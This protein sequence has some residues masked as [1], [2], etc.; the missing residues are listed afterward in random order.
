MT[1]CAL[2]APVRLGSARIRGRSPGLSLPGMCSAGHVC[3]LRPG[4]T[5]LCCLSFLF[6]LAPPRPAGLGSPTALSLPFSAQGG[7]GGGPEFPESFQLFL[8]LSDP[9]LTLIAFLPSRRA[10]VPEHRA[11]ASSP[12]SHTTLKSPA[13]WQARR[14]S[15]DVPALLSVL[16]RCPPPRPQHRGAGLEGLSAPT[17]HK[18]LDAGVS[19]TAPD[20]RASD[21]AAT[22]RRNQ[23]LPA[24]CSATASTHGSLLQPH[25]LP[26]AIGRPERP[27]LSLHCRP[28]RWSNPHGP[29]LTHRPAFHHHHPPPSPA[30]LA[31]LAPL[32]ANQQWR[33]S[34][35]QEARP[36]QPRPP[37]TLYLCPFRAPG[38][39][40]P[41]PHTLPL[42]S[43]S[44]RTQFL[45]RTPIP[46]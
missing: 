4:L 39:P 15:G 9:H 12:G 19:A 28:S 22:Q 30:C 35:L 29:R 14:M 37:A 32:G 42:P 40:P 8:S 1:T 6:S 17:H 25:F 33:F 38:G 43:N 18:L 41:P 10:L 21:A 7:T 45:P 3:T 44:Q 2:H 20:L 26:R 13:D 5:G 16:P 34:A 27:C 31:A 24:F 46:G 36:P 23:G 11:S